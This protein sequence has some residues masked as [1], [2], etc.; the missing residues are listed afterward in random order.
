MA[1]GE[2]RSGSLTYDVKNSDSYTAV[3]RN[4]GGFMGG[5]SAQIYEFKLS[6]ISYGT[7]TQYTT[8]I[9]TVQ[10]ADNLYMYLGFA[11]IISG[12]GLFAFLQKVYLSKQRR[13]SQI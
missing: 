2:G 8:E 3:L 7:E 13:D 4:V 6:A 10:Q 9:Q 1:T 5:S 11:F 12:I